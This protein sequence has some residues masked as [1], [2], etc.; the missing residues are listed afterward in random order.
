MY[1]EKERPI[2]WIGSSRADLRS[3]PREVRRDIGQALYAAQQGEM[4]PAAKPL[5]GFG[6]GSVLEVIVR[7]IGDT[8][9]S[10]YTVRFE[11]AIYVLHV[12]Q[13]KSKRGIATPQREIELVK[14]RLAQAQRMHEEAQR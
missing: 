4:D 6:G 8:Y 12:F 3:F 13:K 7:H 9:R 11:E 5:K 1:N 14:S 10:V 2:V